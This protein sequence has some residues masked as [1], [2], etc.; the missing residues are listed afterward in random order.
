MFAMLNTNEPALCELNTHLLRSGLS[1]ML[2]KRYLIT[3]ISQS[4]TFQTSIDIIFVL[5]LGKCSYANFQIF[6]EHFC[7]VSSTSFCFKTNRLL[8]TFSM[9]KFMIHL[10]MIFLKLSIRFLASIHVPAITRSPL[11]QNLEWHHKLYS[12]SVSRSNR[13]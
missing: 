6:S 12:Q 3:S 5:W 7:F 11:S 13:N 1:H 2:A 10:V 4:K 8:W 9:W